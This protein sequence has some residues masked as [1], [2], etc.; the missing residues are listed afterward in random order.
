MGKR[1]IVGAG[2]ALLLTLAG[3]LFPLAPSASATGSGVI[4]TFTS[5][6]LAPPSIGWG[7]WYGENVSAIVSPADS[8]TAIVATPA[9]VIQQT[10]PCVGHGTGSGSSCWQDGYVNPPPNTGAKAI[11]YKIQMTATYGGITVHSKTLVL[12]VSG[13]PPP[14]VSAFTAA[15]SAVASSGGTESFSAVV[16]SYGTSS[17]VFT[18]S[19]VIA[20]LP[21]TFDCSNNDGSFPT[22]WSYPVPANTSKKAAKYKFSLSVVGSQTVKATPITLTEPAPGGQSGGGLATALA[23]GQGHACAIVTGGAVDCWGLNSNGQLGNGNT[24]N[25]STPVAVTGLSGA[26]AIAAGEDHTCALLAGGTVDCWGSNSSGQLGDSMSTDSSTPVPVSGLSGATAL[27][28]SVTNS[29]AL[30]AGGTVDCWGS[31]SNGQLGNGNATNSSIPVAVTG[32]RGATAIA[33]GQ[34]HVCAVVTGGTV[35]CLGA[36]YYGQ[37]GNGSTTDS[38]TPVAVSGLNGVTAL[39]A[40]YD[41]TCAL[42]AAGNADCW[43]WNQLGALGSG[44]TTDSSTPVAVSGLTGASSISSYGYSACSLEQGQVSCWG[45]FGNGAFGPSTAP[46]MVSGLDT[47]TAVAVGQADACALVSGAVNC[48]GPNYYG[49]LGNGTTTASW[50]PVA[51]SGLT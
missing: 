37:L 27:A 33:A 6:A 42:L 10:N 31:N 43:G 21:F 11:K 32:L 34:D 46:V 36:N 40:G 15:P 12:T 49:E 22:T 30:L 14:T 19:P 48:W 24:T 44:S 7:Y 2:A 41:S 38:W 45:F 47:P 5:L 50:T 13:R 25:S 51:V 3:L 39:A 29:C 4:P 26:T 8:V 28:A 16:K 18:S 23:M 35:Q 1:R 20:G 9:L 17:C